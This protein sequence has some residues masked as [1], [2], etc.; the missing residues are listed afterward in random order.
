MRVAHGDIIVSTQGRSFWILDDRTPLFDVF[1]G[2]VTGVSHLFGTKDAYRADVSG[3][4]GLGG[5]APEP[6]PG[7]ALIRY[8][9]AEEPRDSRIFWARRSARSRATLPQRRRRA[10]IR[11]RWNPE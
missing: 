5:L 8:Y 6:H 4:G 1:D 7:G 3:G 2:T 11:Y 9:L 10:P